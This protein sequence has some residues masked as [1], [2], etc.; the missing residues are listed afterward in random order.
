M[1][2]WARETIASIF[3]PG[4]LLAATV[5]FA[6]PL[7]VFEQAGN[8]PARQAQIFKTDYEAAVAGTLAA[9]RNT[10][11]KDGKE[12]APNVSSVIKSGLTVSSRS[13][14]TLPRTR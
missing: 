12:K 11:F 4:A 13:P 6:V 5:T 7:S 10:H 14:R 8:D 2:N 1:V 3:L 9:L